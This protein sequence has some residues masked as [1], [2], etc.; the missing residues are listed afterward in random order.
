MNPKS[1]VTLLAF[2]LS[3]MLVFFLVLPHMRNVGEARGRVKDERGEITRARAKFDAAKK[4][5]G[6]FNALTEEERAMVESALPQKI[7]VPE[8][9]VLME[10]L[11]VS[12]G[13]VAEEIV[14][15]EEAGGDTDKSLK[16]PAGGETLGKE[17]KVV[18]SATIQ[19]TVSGDYDSL[20]ALLRAL[21][22]SLRIFDVQGMVFSAPKVTKE[23]VESFQFSLTAKTYFKK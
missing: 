3:G 22:Q 19:T 12:S 2:L 23:G 4:A 17:I 21:E 6:Q 5:T 7:N 9:L 20:K 10:S 15:T 1:L 18:G 14:V 11:I 8:L 16:M 13:S